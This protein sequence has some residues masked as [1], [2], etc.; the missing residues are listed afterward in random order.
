MRGWPSLLLLAHDNL[1]PSTRHMQKEVKVDQAKVKS[2]VRGVKMNTDWVGTYPSRY[3]G[4]HDS[5]H[6]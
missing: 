1:S 3:V 2:Q 4:I 6:M 5:L